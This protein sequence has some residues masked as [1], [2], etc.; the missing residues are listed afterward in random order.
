LTRGYN[1]LFDEVTRFLQQV[2][3]DTPL[4]KIVRPQ[5]ISD[6]LIGMPAAV[7]VS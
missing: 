4:E 1:R 5:V 7:A 6:A 2:V 3:R